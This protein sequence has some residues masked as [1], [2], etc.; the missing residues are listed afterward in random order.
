MSATEMV[1]VWGAVPSCQRVYSPM[2]H[3]RQCMVSSS[4]T[5]VIFV[6]P[7]N[8]DDNGTGAQASPYKTLTRALRRA[9]AGMTVQLAPG[10]YSTAT[11]EVFPLVIPP[12]VAVV[13]NEATKGKGIVIDGGGDYL[14]PTFARQSVAIRPEAGSSLR[15]LTVMNRLARGTAI[16]IESTDPAIANC[17]LTNCGREGVFA[18]GTANPEVVN[19][20]FL[21]NAA[22]GLSFFRNAKG[23][24]RRNLCQKTGYGIAI[25]D[26]AAPLVIDNRTLE[27]RAGIAISGSARPVLRNNWVEG[28]SA[29]GLLVSNNAVPDL[30]RS[31]DPGGNVFQNNGSDVHN[32]SAAVLIS[33]GN[34]VNPTRVNV[35]APQTA[36][37]VELVA[38]QA[39]GQIQTVVMKP[40]PTP[41]PT[42]TPQPPTPQPT[43]A[44]APTPAPTPTP[45]PAPTPAPTPETGSLPDIRGHWAEA[46]IRELVK[47]SIITGYPDGTFKPD[48]TLNRAQYAAILA[49]AFDV[50]PKRPASRFVDVATNFWAAAAIV[51]AETMGFLAGFPDRTFRP[52]Q[53]LTRVQTV[54]SLVNGLEL[55]GSNPSFLTVYRDRAEIPTYATGAVAAATQKRLVVNHPRTDEFE[56]MAEITRSEVAAMVYQALVITGQAKAIASPYI[57]VPNPLGVAFADIQTHW[58]AAFIRGLAS[59]GLVS[60]FADGTFKP[61]AGMSRAQYAALLV[62]TFNPLPKRPPVEFRDVSPGHWAAI[63]IQRAYRGRLLSGGGDGTFRPEQAITRIEVLLSLVNGLELPAGNPDLLTY[64]RDAGVVPAFARAAVASA[65]QNRLVVNYP[66]LKQLHPAQAASRAEVTAMVYQALVQAERSPAIASPYIVDPTVPPPEEPSEPPSSGRLTIMLDP[67]HGGSDPGAIGLGGLQEKDVVLAIA[68]ATA[69]ELKKWDLRVVLTRSDDR[70]VSLEDRVLLAEQ[71]KAD[72]FISIHGNAVDNLPDVNG[73]ETYH[74]PNSTKGA[75]LARAIHNQL[76]Q[77]LKPNNRGV[78]QA[79]FYVLRNTSMPA[80]LVEV[81]FV[82]GRIDAANLA[83]A[84][85]RKA[86]GRALATGIAVHAKN[87]VG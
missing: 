40:A 87:P 86:V 41:A 74:Y 42:P 30:G 75:D 31:Q 18:S 53:N 85:Y 7:V 77:S 71:T 61:D 2:S 25:S 26:S 66:D 80:A 84:D 55:S 3:V 52:N 54:V 59:Q 20:V 36:K 5:T 82:T 44:P 73:L 38:S 81:G 21:Q 27:N 43:P 35:N 63:A 56:P 12:G 1:Q 49:K 68:L 10:T 19:N 69:D 14:S 57:V 39:V 4:T 34:Q 64:Y 79:N 33:I 70:T 83:N 72:F 50:P 60:G 15:G 45:A 9:T 76:L 23:E 32:L 47:R 13:G 48:V 28:N 29:E 17:T 24:I 22:S 58:A 78:K 8:G 62:N 46:F 6:N 51:K 37:P 11:G 67:G 65:T 16:W